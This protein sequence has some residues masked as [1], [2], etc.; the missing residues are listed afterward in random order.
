M[1]N[2]ALVFAWLS[3]VQQIWLLY[4]HWGQNAGRA[5]KHRNC[6]TLGADSCFSSPI[7]VSLGQLPKTEEHKQ[8]KI[9]VCHCALSCQE[10]LGFF[11]NVPAQVNLWTFSTRKEGVFAS[12]CKTKKNK[13]DLS[14]PAPKYSAWVSVASSYPSSIGGC[15][16]S[17]YLKIYCGL[18]LR[19]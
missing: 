16:A 2:W 15:K 13:E 1:L 6:R 18:I 10:V 7:A 5:Y 14:L 17:G 8:I 19:K 9:M 3:N 4:T 12:T 11:I